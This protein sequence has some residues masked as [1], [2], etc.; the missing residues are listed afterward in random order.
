MIGVVAYGA[1]TAAGE[2]VEAL[3]SGV[4][5]GRDF[6]RAL[7]CSDWPVKP[8]FAAR[9]CLLPSSREFENQEERLFTHLHRAWREA[10]ADL[11]RG[12]LGRVGVILASTKG[13]VED[14]IWNS[15][16]DLRQDFLAPL[17]TRFCRLAEVTAV[18][19]V[20][21]S[22]ACASSHSAL[23]LATQWF[24]ADRV[25]TVIVLAVDGVGPFVL[26]GFHSLQALSVSSARPFAPDRDGMRLGEAAVVVVLAS[27]PCAIGL[28][29]VG[30]DAEGFAAVRPSPSGQSL[31]RALRALASV[32][33]MIIAHATATVLNDVVEDQV[34]HTHFGLAPVVT[35]SKWS[36]GHTLAAC[37]AVDLVLACESIIRRTGFRLGNTPEVDPSFRCR[38][39]T[40]N[41]ALDVEPERVLFSALGFGGIHAVAQVERWLDA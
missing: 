4:H 13:F 15:N 32:P 1:S 3:W 33:D 8:D 22:N 41:A 37:G 40:Q 20:V 7:D 19:Q 6:S 24:Q 17:L 31:R 21:V 26:Q 30:L 23:W 2:G 36:I 28:T 12:Q 29:G 34:F 11:D 10:S 25:D 5:S 9:A 38:Y 27:K 18:T 16:S 14:R 35:G 39:L